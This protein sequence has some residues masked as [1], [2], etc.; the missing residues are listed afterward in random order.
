MPSLR[1]LCAKVGCNTTVSV[2]VLRCERHKNADRG[3]RASSH[4]RGYDSRW[5][6]ARRFFLNA[7]PLCAECEREGRTTEANVV[8]HVE[9]HRG[10]SDLFWDESNWQALCESCHNAKSAKERRHVS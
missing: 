6:K 2:G 3:K 4:A 9:P 5:R 8:D 1:K 7:H 10:D